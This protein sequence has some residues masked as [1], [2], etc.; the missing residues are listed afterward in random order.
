MHS[1]LTFQQQENKKLTE[2]TKTLKDK[3]SKAAECHKQQML[4]RDQEWKLHMDTKTTAVSP[5]STNTT[6]NWQLTST[7]TRKQTPIGNNQPQKALIK[8]MAATYT[9]IPYS[10]TPQGRLQPNSGT[11]KMAQ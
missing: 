11:N 1:Q 4:E 9:T 10:H 8:R 7:Y 6:R 3:L 5:P 2:L